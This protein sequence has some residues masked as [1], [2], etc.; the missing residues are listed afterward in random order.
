MFCSGHC[1][2]A[3]FIYFGI[4]L[5]IH[6]FRHLFIYSFTRPFVHLAVCDGGSRA[7]ECAPLA[8]VRRHRAQLPTAR[9]LLPRS[10]SCCGARAMRCRQSHSCLPPHFLPVYTHNWAVYTATP[11]AICRAQEISLAQLNDCFA[12]LTRRAVHP[13]GDAAGDDGGGAAQ[14]RRG[15]CR[16]PGSAGPRRARQVHCPGVCLSY[17]V[18]IVRSPACT[19]DRGCSRRAQPLSSTAL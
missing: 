7:E 19:A 6:L 4:Y 9:R 12:R 3:L 1:W 14:C 2:A 10:T 16:A 11:P 17:L 13:A 5:F 15:R 18:A 8:G